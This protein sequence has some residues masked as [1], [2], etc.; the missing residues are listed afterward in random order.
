MN[1]STYNIPVIDKSV[2]NQNK[3]QVKVYN[4]IFQDGHGSPDFKGLGPIL[5]GMLYLFLFSVILSLPEINYY[6]AV[7]LFL[8]FIGRVLTA[9]RL[10]YVETLNQTGHD[11]YFIRMNMLQNFIE[12]FVALFV[13][14]YVLFGHILAK[15]NNASRR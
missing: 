5:K 7:L 8:F 6:F 1:N 10:F 14:L 15:K 2:N 13:A 3:R 11:I 12:G 9:I 4:G